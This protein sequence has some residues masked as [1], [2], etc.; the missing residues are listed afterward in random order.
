MTHH[1]HTPPRPDPQLSG[2]R[3]LALWLVTLPKV[4]V[5]VARDLVLAWR[6]REGHR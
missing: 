1:H 3:Y 6:E 5:T 2:P 4:L